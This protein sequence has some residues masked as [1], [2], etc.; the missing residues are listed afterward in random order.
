MAVISGTVQRNHQGWPH[1]PSC[2]SRCR[3]LSKKKDVAL[4]QKQSTS[5]LR[6][7]PVLRRRID[8]HDLVVASVFPYF[9]VLSSKIASFGTDTPIVTTWH[10]VWRDYWDDYLGILAP[11]GKI[12][13]HLTARV[14]QH[15][16]AVSGITADRLAEIGPSRNEIEVVHN[17]IDVEQIRS[18]PLP[19]TPYRTDGGTGFDV[20][21]RWATYC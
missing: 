2:C 4:S 11:G 13:E 8:E 3:T 5:P 16:I 12:I 14:P 7:A 1:S 21:F 6:L 9:P 10:E 15:P 17:G 19:E 18:A 20:S